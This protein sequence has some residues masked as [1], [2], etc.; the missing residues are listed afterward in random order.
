MHFD[1]KFGSTTLPLDL[2]DSRIL[3]VVLPGERPPLEDPQASVR[4]VLASPEGS[5]PLLDLLKAA[6]PKRLV[7]VVNDITRPTPY[8]VFM[9]PLVE[10][11][12]KAGI[13][14]SCVTL[15]TATGI[16]DPHTREQDIQVYGEDLCSRFKVLSHDATDAANLT[17]KGKLPSGYD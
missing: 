8:S 14:D 3:E 4:H 15:L 12:E 7:I 1:L 11:I 16:H 17:Y 10:T 9:P 13:P 2:E 5:P 6:N